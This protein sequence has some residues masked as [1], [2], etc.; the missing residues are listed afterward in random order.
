MK[1]LLFSLFT[2]LAFVTCSDDGTGVE[3]DKVI[4]L[5]TPVANIEPNVNST[6]IKFFAA[7][8]WTAEVIITRA[9]DWC[10]ISPTSGDAGE[11]TI[12]VTT[13]TN[14]TPKERFAQIVIKSGET[15]NTI[16]VIQKQYLQPVITQ[17]FA[18]NK[19]GIWS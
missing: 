11:A 15:E 10:S 6:V 19:S 16:K 13:K 12:T 1:K 18:S 17:Y 4:K 8:P 3:E 7:E 9:D 5:E 14:K 2:I